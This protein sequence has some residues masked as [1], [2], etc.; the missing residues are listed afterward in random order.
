M[1]L[2]SKTF[3]I[4]SAICLVAGLAT[5]STADSLNGDERGSILLELNGIQDILDGKQLSLRTSA[6]QTFQA[7]S[8]SNDAAYEFYL[9]C[10]KIL[11][12]DPKGA[13]Y[14]EFRNW[15]DRQEDKVKTESNLSA[16]RVQLQYLVLSMKAAE[17]AQLDAIIPELEQ[18]VGNIAANSESL[19]MRRM[20]EPVTKTI[21]AQA[22]DLDKSLTMENWSYSPGNYS[23]VY[24]RT[25]FPFFRATA[26]QELAAAWDRRIALESGLFS[27]THEGNVEAL[28]KFQREGLPT[29][30]WRKSMDLYV[31]VSQ[32]QGAAALIQIVRANP[33][34]PD[35]RNW[36][37]SFAKLLKGTTVSASEEY[38]KT[39]KQTPP[40]VDPNNP[41]GFE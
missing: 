29:L 33:E 40:P 30:Y 32:K 1:K 14:T 5:P 38:P 18:F 24:E 3:L 6:G 21:F 20:Q 10:H 41:L 19:N 9:K 4:P 37:G 27:R 11:N 16:M 25:I 2:S 34:H 28:E 36:V 15:R 22:Y 8:A 13:S 7:A 17:S 26:T 31:S 23:E 39:T 12:F 35:I